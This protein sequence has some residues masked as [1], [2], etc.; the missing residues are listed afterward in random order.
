MLTRELTS[1]DLYPV[2]GGQDVEEAVVS[3]LVAL[4]RLE[5][6]EQPQ[7]VVEGDHDHLT[8]PI[9]QGNGIDTESR[10]C[11]YFA[12]KRTRSKYFAGRVVNILPHF[13]LSHAGIP[14]FCSVRQGLFNIS[15]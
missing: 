11:K 12:R 9:L 8:Q 4:P 10:T 7:P 5:E 2:Q 15:Y 6:A 13:S 1:A 14:I 3:H